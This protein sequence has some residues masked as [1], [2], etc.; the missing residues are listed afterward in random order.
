MLSVELPESDITLRLARIDADDK[1]VQLNLLG[2][3]GEK[4]QGGSELMVSE[5]SNV[6]GERS[7]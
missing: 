6:R 3:E 2:L 5:Y 4:T 7:L 1:I